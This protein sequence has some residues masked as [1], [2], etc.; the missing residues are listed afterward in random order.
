MAGPLRRVSQN[1]NWTI[2]RAHNDLHNSI[3]SGPPPAPAPPPDVKTVLPWD[4]KF[5]S[6]YDELREHLGRSLLILFGWWLTIGRL[7]EQFVADQAISQLYKQS[8]KPAIR[9]TLSVSVWGLLAQLFPIPVP[10]A[11]PDQPVS[12]YKQ[13]AELSDR[14]IVPITVW[15]LFALFFRYAIPQI[16]C[17]TQPFFSRSANGSSADKREESDANPASS[18]SARRPLPDEQ[19]DPDQS[20]NIESTANEHPEDSPTITVMSDPA[21]STLEESFMDAQ[22][23]CSERLQSAIHIGK[24]MLFYG[25]PTPDGDIGKPHKYAID[26]ASYIH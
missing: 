17:Y 1:Y 20:P 6:E 13:S 25:S 11:Q 7:I 8:S 24:G 23:D 15:G 21:H 26:V 19:P 18:H 5:K 4:W 12:L 3:T 22:K 2:K 14:G 9:D 16:A 10:K